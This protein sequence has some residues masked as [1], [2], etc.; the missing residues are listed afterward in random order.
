MPLAPYPQQVL[1]GDTITVNPEET[2]RDRDKLELWRRQLESSGAR[3]VL[4]ATGPMVGPGP[5]GQP[6]IS[7]KEGV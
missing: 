4:L 2:G 5:A 1:W 3:A 6:P 7:W